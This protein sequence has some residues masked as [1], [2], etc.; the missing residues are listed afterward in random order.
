MAATISLCM[1]TLNEEKN[2]RRCLESV[3]GGVD[4]IIIVDTGSTDATCQIARE[5]G[6]VVQFY[7]WNDS[8]SDARNVS[9]ELASGDWILF[10]DADEELSKDS[11][12]VLRKIVEDPTVEGYFLTIMNY[13]GDE[14]SGNQSPDAVFRLFRN[15]PDYRF[16]G[17]VH[18]HVIGSIL[19]KNSQPQFR[20]DEGLIL[21]HYGYLN[22]QMEEKD[23]GHRNL[24]LIERG[25]E[26]EPDNVMMQYYYGTEL[27]R[28][29][30]YAKAAAQ[31]VKAAEGN[32]IHVDHLPKLLRNLVLAYYQGHCPDQALETIEKSLKKFPEFAD[33]Y[34]LQGS[35][36][37]DGQDY[38]RAYAAF[39]QALA[40][41]KQPVYYA[42][43]PGTRGFRT[44]YCLGRL[45]QKY[46]N[47][48]EARKYYSLSLKD[49]PKFTIALEALIP[50]LE[51][52]TD[53]AH[54]RAVLDDFPQDRLLIAGLLMRQQ[55]SKLA[56]EYLDKSVSEEHL[57]DGLLLQKAVCL[58]QERHL[59]EALQLLERFSTED[60]QYPTV[61]LNR[62]LCYW[63]QDDDAKACLLAEELINMGSSS[64]EGVV[65][66]LVRDRISNASSSQLVL[67]LDASGTALL[68]DLVVRFM[69]LGEWEKVEALLTGVSEGWRINHSLELGRLCYHL[70]NDEMAERYLKQHLATQKSAEA[71]Y[72]L[73]EIKSR[74]GKLLE[75]G[76]FYQQVVR[77][78]PK[79]PLSYVR[80]KTIYEKLHQTALEQPSEPSLPSF[81]AAAADSFAAKANQVVAMLDECN[82]LARSLYVAL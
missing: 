11:V 80:L 43:L 25:V 39:Q 37:Y 15:R 40:T 61:K 18:E 48:E 35:I 54:A 33:L 72:L 51:P 56:L 44:Y 12:P 41:P 26:A 16:S 47:K 42:S 28:F 9:L 58:I 22:N 71:Y 30:E 64:N 1:I 7:T 81:C 6:A 3:R 79:E 23:K 24:R 10:L 19:K 45:A 60:P 78:E 31:F 49:N 36:Y 66:R 8:F 32:A 59:L 74:S 27:Y 65:I 63:L 29:G 77:L 34:Y 69:D 38:G 46:G 50:L 14:G 20:F 21:F 62:L 17:A 52:R 67:P 4:E 53:V 70:D 75:A 82:F 76:E 5:Y 2:L 68:M 73:G 13:V 57:L 55:A